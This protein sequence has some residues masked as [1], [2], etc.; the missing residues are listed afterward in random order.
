[1]LK[2]ILHWNRYTQEWILQDAK[3]GAM[4]Q[5]LEDCANT[6]RLFLGASKQKD[7]VWVLSAK[8]VK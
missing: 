3:S 6:R 8:R 7:G 5:R 1:M 2:V 4:L